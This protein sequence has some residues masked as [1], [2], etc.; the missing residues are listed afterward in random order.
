MIRI[1]IRLL[2]D[3]YPYPKNNN[4]YGYDF[5]IIHLYPIRLHPYSDTML[6]FVLCYLFVTKMMNNYISLY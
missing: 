3:P 6:T 5:A 1:H 2:S 4:G